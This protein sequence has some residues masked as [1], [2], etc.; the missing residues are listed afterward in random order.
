MTVPPGPLPNDGPVPPP[1]PFPGPGGVPAPSH[2]PPGYPWGPAPRPAR[3]GKNLLII[4]AALLTT[5]VIAGSLA[6]WLMGSIFGAQPPASAQ[7]ASGT[8]TTV[9]FA[10]GE[11]KVIYVDGADT[12]RVV[13]SNDAS[14]STDADSVKIE[15]FSGDVTI[16][17]WKAA[18]SVTA[19]QAGTYAFSC[20]GS[21]GDTFGL[22]G[23]ASVGGIGG[24]VAL[25][26]LAGATALA[27]LI[28]GTIGLVRQLRH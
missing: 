16:N 19:P 6:A 3:P 11:T 7:F 4:A 15:P 21:P 2:P 14:E 24:T 18:F 10:A 5:A 25:I 20:D 26:L 8:S 27:G 12:S 23:R 9:E 22:G 28:T 1:A 17:D 13:C